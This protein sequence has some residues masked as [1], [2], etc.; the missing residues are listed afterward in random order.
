MR[1]KVLVA[2]SGGIDSAMVAWLLMQQGYEIR[3]VH[4]LFHENTGTSVPDRL[5]FIKST[6]GINLEIC[7]VRDLFEREVVGYLTRMHLEGKTPSPC[8]I[9]NPKVKWHVL[10]ELRK[11][12]SCDYFA[13]GHYIRIM[14][15]GQQKRICKGADPLKDQSY[16]LW[17]ITAAQLKYALAPLGD[18]TKQEVRR[19]AKEAGLDSLIR[20]KESMGLCFSDHEHYRDFLL[21]KI[22]TKGIGPGMV[23][24]REGK[25]AG[26]HTGYPY[27][28]I[29]QKKALNLDA[30]YRK[31]CVA[32]ILPAE[33]RLI[34]DHWQNLYTRDLSIRE[35]HFFDDQEIGKKNPLQ[36][37]VRGFGLNPGNNA[38]IFRE[39]PEILR[40][41][42]EEPA[43]AIAPG[44]PV[45][46]YSGDLL[47][48][49]GIA[50]SPAESCQEEHP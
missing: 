9:C 8:A 4:F 37:K 13:T 24:D 5:E 44:Q 42:L 27:Y 45:V 29:G 33:N 19:L 7:D 41:R 48:G 39:S 10:T 20:E 11:T 30:A 26:K 15:L 18:M 21:E 46:F 12:F 25:Y 17:G 34:V 36:V 31:W 2:L 50:C 6:L 3:G 32:E 1:S 43:W 23:Y 22:G 49:G 40:V 35:Y 28:T 14:P 47:V 38:F 16:Y